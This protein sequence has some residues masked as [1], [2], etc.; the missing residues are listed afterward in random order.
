MLRVIDLTII[1]FSLSL[2]IAS[3]HN[4]SQQRA[5]LLWRESVPWLAKGLNFAATALGVFAAA[6]TAARFF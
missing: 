5:R 2:E 6:A 3:N 4:V 1:D